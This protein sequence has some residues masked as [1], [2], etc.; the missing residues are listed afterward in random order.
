MSLLLKLITEILLL[1]A[2]VVVAICIIG[3][4]FGLS[5]VIR[6]EARHGRRK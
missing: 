5:E 3:F 1:V 6:Y 2:A 4:L